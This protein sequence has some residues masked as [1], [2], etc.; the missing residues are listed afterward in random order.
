MQAQKLAKA[1]CFT[2]DGAKDVVNAFA[3]LQANVLP[4]L[5][6]S[7]PAAGAPWKSSSSPLF[8]LCALPSGELGFVLPT[9]LPAEALLLLF[10]LVLYF[11]VNVMPWLVHGAT[12]GAPARAC[13]TLAVVSACYGPL[14]VLLARLI[15]LPVCLPI[16]DAVFII[17]W[18]TWGDCIE[19]IAFLGDVFGPW[20]PIANATLALVFR[21]ARAHGA[22]VSIES[23]VVWARARALGF[24]AAGAATVFTFPEL[25]GA[26]GGSVLGLGML[27]SEMWRI[28]AGAG[29]GAAGGLPFLLLL[30][31]HPCFGHSNTSRA[32]HQQEVFRALARRAPAELRGRFAALLDISAVVAATAAVEQL[33]LLAT[34]S[35]AALLQLQRLYPARALALLVARLGASRAT[36]VGLALAAAGSAAY[37]AILFLS[38]QLPNQAL[39]LATNRDVAALA[40]WL[41]LPGFEALTRRQV[42]W[43]FNRL[44]ATKTWAGAAIAEAAVAQLSQLRRLLAR[45]LSCV[46]GGAIGGAASAARLRLIMDAAGA[47]QWPLVVAGDKFAQEGVAALLTV[48]LQKATEL[49]WDPV[50]VL[51]FIT[52]Q[53]GLAKGQAAAQLFA[54]TQGLSE[55]ERRKRFAA[56]PGGLSYEQAAAGQAGL[57]Q[58]NDDA[59]LLA[60]NMHLGQAGLLALFDGAAERL[61]AA[62]AGNV[63]RRAAGESCSC[64]HACARAG[65]HKRR[66]QPRAASRILGRPGP[67]EP[68]GFLVVPGQAEGVRVGPA[69]IWHCCPPPLSHCL[70]C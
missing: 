10:F 60:A 53:A 4:P 23:K 30:G 58:A 31:Y 49:D 43:L 8:F 9:N 35:F 39:A 14:L 3:H 16:V 20:Q 51:G 57:E 50:T 15:G 44:V 63:Q 32:H 45:R 29:A 36:R 65:L 41:W 38:V 1:V 59:K 62:N 18:P 21:L 61:A 19:V 37:A 46:L 12:A 17:R 56:V 27:T 22:D 28:A 66:L 24:L 54:A 64:C 26:S 13:Y 48:T 33:A 69:L 70:L 25:F 47:D 52:G 42:S 67:G 34:A 5:I 55:L 68:S 7:L 11:P 6:A 2:P 40:T